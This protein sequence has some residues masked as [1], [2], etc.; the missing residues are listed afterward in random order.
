M[1][2]QAGSDLTIRDDLIDVREPIRALGARHVRLERVTFRCNGLPLGCLDVRGARS[3][4]LR[5]CAVIGAT[6]KP[7]IRL[8]DVTEV[9]IDELRLEP[10]AEG[11][12]GG[13]LMLDGYGR[14]GAWR[15][16]G[17]MV[18]GVTLH[19]SLAEQNVDVVLVHNPHNLA[20]SDSAFRD[21]AGYDGAWDIG[22]KP[23]DAIL[24]PSLAVV[25][26]CEMVDARRAKLTGYAGALA[27]AHRLEVRAS[28]FSG[29]RFEPYYGVRTECEIISTTFADTDAPPIRLGSS[30]RPNQGSL[31]VRG[32]RNFT[33]HQLIDAT[34]STGEIRGTDSVR[35][36]A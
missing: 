31:S 35:R 22:W 7:A 34:Y 19:P 1:I 9:D 29:T 25:R 28:R 2:I 16:S 8:E 36:A 23:D 13:L 33:G 32:V 17:L 27:G 20:L 12:A 15:V 21:I 26:G 18:E 10:D 4:T 6:A 24:H 11:Y 14:T 3:V 30:S 5:D